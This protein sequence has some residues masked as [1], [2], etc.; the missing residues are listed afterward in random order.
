MIWAAKQIWAARNSALAVEQF[1]WPNKF[2]RPET[3]VV[4]KMLGWLG[5]R[6]TPL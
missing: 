3:W 1:G 6:K 5:G 4:K 2:R